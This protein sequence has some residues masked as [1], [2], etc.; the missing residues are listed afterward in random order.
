MWRW[1]LLPFSWLYGLILRLRHWA[2]DIG[3]LHS[4]RFKQPVIV[5]GNLS[6]G[7][8][9]KTP[10]TI[11]LAQMLQEFSPAILSRG[12]GRST[13]GFRWV[14]PTDTAAE[15]GDEPV[16][17]KRVLGAVDV[18]VCED[19]VSG[20]R[21]MLD[22]RNP[23]V[24]LLDDAFQ[25]RKLVPGFA[26]VLVEYSS[27]FKPRF[28]LPAGDERDVWMR[29]KAAQVIVVTKCPEDISAVEK[30]RIRHAIVNGSASPLPVFFSRLQYGHIRSF[31]GAELT[32]Q[33]QLQAQVILVTGIARPSKLREDLNQ[34]T[35]VVEH[36]SYAD[37][38]AFGASDLET[39]RKNM[40]MFA[41]STTWFITTSKD[42]V[43]IEPLLNEEE[44]A[45][46]LEIPVA[47]NIIDEE[48][49][50]S[51][52]LAYVRSTA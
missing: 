39:M 5:V 3:V 34:M 41:P 29:R 10:Q 48:K 11:Q 47:T 26:V 27:F 38:Y 2:Y 46:W 50:N 31:A 51:L 8:T 20:I 36:L 9:G 19:R 12:Y 22:E 42:R 30:E 23:G 52:I 40:A 43:R 15:S 25:H 21:R 13:R 17:F 18:A 24:I 44:K 49:F 45:R 33:E 28:L 6:L 7:G 4:T 1:I 16:L 14:N 37:H 35:T 32:S